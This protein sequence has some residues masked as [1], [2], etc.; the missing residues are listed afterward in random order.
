MIFGSI[1][2][3]EKKNFDSIDVVK[4]NLIKEYYINEILVIMFVFIMFRIPMAYH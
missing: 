3:P 1:L 4:N 2:F